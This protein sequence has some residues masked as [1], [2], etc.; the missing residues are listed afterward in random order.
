MNYFHFV[1]LSSSLSKK[2]METLQ[3]IAI[4]YEKF[5]NGKEGTEADSTLPEKENQTKSGGRGVVIS[6]YLIILILNLFIGDSK[7]SIYLREPTRSKI[8]G[9]K[10]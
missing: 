6:Y 1:F 2:N 7:F 3:E 10:R 5:L 8:E 4:L 9:D